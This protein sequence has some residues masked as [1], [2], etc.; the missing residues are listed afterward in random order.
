METVTF[1]VQG[2]TCNGCVG[3]VKRVLEALPGVK[4]ADVTLAPGEASVAF[5]ASRVTAEAL[6]EA[7]KDAGYDVGCE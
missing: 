1:N 2:M 3:S 5:D 7:V 4:H 6:R